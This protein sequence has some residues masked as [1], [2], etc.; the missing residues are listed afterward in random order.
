[1]TDVLPGDVFGIFYNNG[2]ENFWLMV[3]ICR[4]NDVFEATMMVENSSLLCK[5]C[6]ATNFIVFTP[7]EIAK[8]VL[9]T[10][11]LGHPICFHCRQFEYDYG[12]YVNIANDVLSEDAEM[13]PSFTE[14]QRWMSS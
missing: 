4:Y 3:S 14:K 7:E 13:L 10:D 12:S 1:M 8:F 6:L 9:E 11:Q 2:R 5:R